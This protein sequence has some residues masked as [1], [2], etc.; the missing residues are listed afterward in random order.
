MRQ[1]AEQTKNRVRLGPA[2]LYGSIQALQEAKF[3]EEVDPPAGDAA[4][5]RRRYYRIT[6]SGRKTARAE[7][8]RMVGA[9][10]VARA[11][12]LLGGELV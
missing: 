5:E 9:L 11:K 2:T 6:A 3:I 8:E 1:V 10:R 4:D 12:K 7:A